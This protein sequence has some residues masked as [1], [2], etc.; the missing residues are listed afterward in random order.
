MARENKYLNVNPYQLSREELQ[1]AVES[2]AKT[3]NQRLT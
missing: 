2:M 1:R 3:A